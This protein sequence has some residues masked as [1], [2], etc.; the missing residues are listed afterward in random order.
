MGKTALQAVYAINNEG[1]TRLLLFQ[2]INHALKLRAIAFGRAFYN[3]EHLNNVQTFAFGIG[4]QIGKLGLKG[5]AC[6]LFG[7]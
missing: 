3:A 1:V 5:M 6:F 2:K 7:C 4:L